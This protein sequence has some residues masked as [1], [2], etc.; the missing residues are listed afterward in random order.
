MGLPDGDG[1]AHLTCDAGQVSMRFRLV[2]YV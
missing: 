2:L 1:S